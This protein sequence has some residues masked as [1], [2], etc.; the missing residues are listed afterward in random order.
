MFTINYIFYIEGGE[1]VMINYQ[2]FDKNTYIKVTILS[3]LYKRDDWYTTS[4]LS[5]ASSINVK[6]LKKYAELLIDDIQQLFSE[7]SNVKIE[8]V[9]R[10]GYRFCGDKIAFQ[11]I[12]RSI[13]E[14]SVTFS[15]LQD[16]LLYGTLDIDKFISAHYISESRFRKKIS[17]INYFLSPSSLSIKTKKQYIYLE[18]KELQVRFFAYTYFWGIYKGLDWPFTLVSEEELSSAIE[19]EI[20]SIL[21]LKKISIA[22]WSYVIALNIHRIEANAELNMSSL[23]VFTNALNAIYDTSKKKKILFIL[24][25]FHYFSKAEIQYLFLLFQTTVQFY[26]IDNYFARALTFHKNNQTE[27]YTLYQL[28]FSCFQPNLKKADK[29]TKLSYNSLV[30]VTFFSLFLFPNGSTTF[31]GHDYERY[32]KERYPY[33]RNE[34]N[35]RLD[36]CR[37]RSTSHLLDNQEFLLSRFA[38]LHGMIA[39]L[40]EFDPLIIINLETDLP[41]IMEKILSEQ[42]ESVLSTFYHVSIYILKEKDDYSNTDLVISTTNPLLLKKKWSGKTAFIHASLIPKDIYSLIQIIEIIYREKQAEKLLNSSSEPTHDINIHS[43]ESLYF[44]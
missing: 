8:Y 12:H 31:S 24:Q 15:L 19:K 7:T 42:I 26:S 29:Q 11:T 43:A 35:A 38:E 21:K 39:P 6:T 16:L 9:K 25:N 23:P 22:Q 13:I 28:Y 2:L 33:L 44:F 36:Q 30:L 41:F 17:E 14:Q 20:G 40:V 10:I 1:Y 27:V 3:L 5:S 37:K 4:D 34:M 32:L 18:G